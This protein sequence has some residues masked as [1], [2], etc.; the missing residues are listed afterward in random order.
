VFRARGRVDEPGQRHRADG[1]AGGG[2]STTGLWRA[3]LPA[4]CARKSA[5]SGNKTE[6]NKR[7]RRERHQEG[8]SGNNG[9]KTA[10]VPSTAKKTSRLMCAGSSTNTSV[11][12]ADEQDLD[13]TPFL[14]QCREARTTPRP[15]ESY[16]VPHLTVETSS[17]R[18]IEA[19]VIKNSWVKL[20]PAMPRRSV[21]HGCGCARKECVKLCHDH[22]N[23]AL[24]DKACQYTSPAYMACGGYHRTPQ[25]LFLA[26]AGIA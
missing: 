17:A 18:K 3:R 5:G 11:G 24:I 6:N 2:W 15:P 9:G 10:A 1:K 23:H 25:V 14:N 26:C 13:R 21:S 19:R 22:R 12:N 7:C 16:S 4:I 8:E 20:S